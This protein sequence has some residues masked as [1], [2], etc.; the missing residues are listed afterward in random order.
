MRYIRFETKHF[1]AMLPLSHCNAV[2]ARVRWQVEF[3]DETLKFYQDPQLN[4]DAQQ[5]KICKSLRAT[6]GIPE[7]VQQSR[8]R[9][10]HPPQ[11]TRRSAPTDVSCVLR[12]GGGRL[13]E[14]RG[15][16]LGS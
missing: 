13:T 14:R 10:P 9:H 5:S 4:I 1:R 15:G 3:L 16:D 2:C 7:T 12:V 8:S 11:P 6:W